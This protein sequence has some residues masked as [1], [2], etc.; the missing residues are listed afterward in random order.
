MGGA[1]EAWAEAQFRG[2]DRLDGDVCQRCIIDDDLLAL[3]ALHRR[4]GTC[5]FCGKKKATVARAALIQRRIMDCLL[6]S[7]ERLEDSGVP[8][9]GRE[10]GFQISP[11]SGDEVVRGEAS[12]AVSDK[13][14]EKVADQAM[15]CEWVERD[16]ALLHPYQRLTGG[17]EDFCRT[18][19]HR[20]RYSFAFE[21]ETD[22]GHPD[23]TS[24]VKTLLSISDLVDTYKL[25][26]TVKSGTEVIRLRV[27]TRE[28]Y[29]DI[30]KLGTPPCQ[31]AKANRMSPAGISMFYGA[32][33]YET[34]VKETWDGVNA[35]LCSKGTFVTK[36]NIRIVDFTRLP[37]VPGYWS[38]PGRDHLA[39]I[40]FMHALAQDIS[41]PVKRNDSVDLHYAPTQIVAEY[42]LKAR[43]YRPS[44][45]GK[46]AEDEIHGVVFGSSHTGKPNFALNVYNSADSELASGNIQDD[47]LELVKVEHLPLMP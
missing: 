9:D 11:S 35:A 37:P 24:P 46:D 10:G 21:P 31:F 42:L 36:R 18:V 13:F 30:G 28:R 2:Y 41:Q 12:G 19:R 23:S 3:H 14:L 44:R 7:Y 34:A 43:H 33:D 1:K 47:W 17:W 4:L 15:N 25:I 6:M 27:N 29:S 39:T 26:R 20:L 38:N 8:Y 32:F 5:S 22:E 45:A 16:W 40:R